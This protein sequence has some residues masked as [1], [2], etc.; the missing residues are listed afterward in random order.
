MISKNDLPNRIIFGDG[1][2]AVDER[3]NTTVGSTVL[4]D[5]VND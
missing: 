3:D 4:I 1:Y 5:W 2:G